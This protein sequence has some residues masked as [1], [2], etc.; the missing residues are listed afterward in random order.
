MALLLEFD[1][2]EKKIFDITEASV[3]HTTF[4]YRNKIFTYHTFKS[5]KIIDKILRPES[6]QFTDFAERG[7]G[8]E[9]SNGVVLSTV[10]LYH[11]SRPYK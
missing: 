10:E 2:G 11:N 1:N 7:Q 4:R 3:D 6:Y 8:V 9:F 5:A